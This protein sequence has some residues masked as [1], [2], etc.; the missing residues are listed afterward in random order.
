MWVRFDHLVA[1]KKADRVMREAR[2]ITF[3]EFESRFPRS[4]MPFSSAIYTV[5]NR[6][7]TRANPDRDGDDFEPGFI[8]N[9]PDDRLDE[10]YEL[11]FSQQSKVIDEAGAKAWWI[12]EFG[13]GN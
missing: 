6:S 5:R 9:N 11:D 7:S 8:V 2:W 13:G 10:D 3:A 4:Q 1:T 12:S